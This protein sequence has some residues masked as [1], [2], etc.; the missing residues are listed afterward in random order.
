[1]ARSK[2]GEFLWNEFLTNFY[3]GGYYEF[4]YKNIIVNIGL[5]VEGKF[6]KKENWVF[7]AHNNDNSRK[8]LIYS[9]FLTPQLLLENARVEGKSL[10]DIWDNLILCD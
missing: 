6:R 1:M 7:I 8:L 5:D 4:N 9:S 3:N 2:D 10:Q